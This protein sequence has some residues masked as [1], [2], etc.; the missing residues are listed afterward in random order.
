MIDDR[1]I[2][3]Y[4][5]EA[6]PYPT[7][8]DLD[9]EEL[10][11]SAAAV[12]ARRNTGGRGPS[13]EASVRLAPKPARQRLGWVVAAVAFVAV[14][15]GI[16]ITAFLL[17]GSDVPV[18]DEPATSTTMPPAEEVAPGVVESLALGWGQLVDD[19]V[20]RKMGATC[21]TP[22][23]IVSPPLIRCVISPL[24]G[25]GFYVH[26]DSV[27]DEVGAW[28]LDGGVT[29]AEGLLPGLSE[30][31]VGRLPEPPVAAGDRVVVAAGD[32]QTLWVGDPWSGSWE[33]IALDVAGLT[34]SAI[35]A[36]AASPDEALVIGRGRGP[37]ADEAGYH[38]VVWL[39]DLAGK[40]SERHVLPGRVEP[41]VDVPQRQAGDFLAAWIDPGWV[42]APFLG[43]DFDVLFSSDGTDWASVGLPDK[44]SE[45]G[46]VFLSSLVAGDAGVVVLGNQGAHKVQLL[47]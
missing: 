8:A 20:A 28:S 17:R 2:Q 36:V 24:P 11:R 29:W 43:D 4:L 44:T 33:P 14:L 30:E 27:N 19:P 9:P 31:Q 15:V 37:V 40:T 32:A 26:P 34:D 46:E 16:G 47:L 13:Y 3:E 18:V 23:V 42:V 21:Q 7:V 25:E 6:N 35:L 39:V 41:A 38:N 45:E 1:V 10:A 12:E 5:R 22:G